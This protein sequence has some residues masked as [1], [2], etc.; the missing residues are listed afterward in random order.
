MSD[1]NQVPYDPPIRKR[2]ASLPRRS[3]SFASQ[4]AASSIPPSYQ[5]DPRRSSSLSL[6][7]STALPP[8]YHDDT[9]SSTEGTITD[10]DNERVGESRPNTFSRVPPRDEEADLI[11][12]QDPKDAAMDLKTQ[13]P[14]RMSK[15]WEEQGVS[16]SDDMEQFLAQLY[17]LTH[18]IDA[19]DNDIDQIKA[20]R[21]K[22][23]SIDPQEDIGSVSI[24]SDLDA[25]SHLVTDT[26]RAILSLETWL[27][28]LV[29]RNKALRALVK[30]G[31][32]KFRPEEIGEVKFQLASAKLDFADGMERIR[33]YAWKE[34]EKR[35]R[36]RM[37]IARH[38]R[39]NEPMIP[40]KDVKAL[41][42]AAEL[43]AAEGIE[44]N[45]V[46]SYAGL[47]ALHNPFTELAELT[48]G[49][50]FLH[51]NLDSEIVDQIVPKLPGK[52]TKKSNSP[53]IRPN[54][55][56]DPPS[57]GGSRLSYFSRVINH[58]NDRMKALE[59][60]VDGA[61]KNVQY[62]FAEQQR[63]ERSIRRKKLIVAL[64]LSIIVGLILL[65]V[66]A[67]AT[68]PDDDLSSDASNTTTVDLFTAS[69]VNPLTLLS[70]STS[71]SSPSSSTSTS[72]TLSATS[73]SST[74][75]SSSSSSVSD[76]F[77]ST[78]PL[79]LTVTSSPSSTDSSS[80]STASSQSTTAWWTPAAASTAS[81]LSG[82][83]QMRKRTAVRWT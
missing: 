7:Q 29:N 64:L 3:N 80:A 40:D 48:S 70:Q 51:D 56:D 78:S 30:S 58:G 31:E 22:I 77:S 44:Q 55:R 79:G 75:S 65:V 18:A 57:F 38:I 67:M 17:D 68:V 50:K 74:Q 73:I 21:K 34:Q 61:E 49:M 36:T 72:G 5:D 24:K 41:L 35:M 53:E 16:H 1:F 2:S 66:L 63:L 8:S 76:T 23:A 42:K 43:G 12:L 25:Q 60:E 82:S 26:G 47:W 69:A 4:G 13:R 37:K 81:S 10:S 62:G 20:L 27:T 6:A 45:D 19:L 54:P 33:E 15:G 59:Q 28:A 39:A 11:G 83:L 9:D 71:N 14:G 46:T 52:K 32:A